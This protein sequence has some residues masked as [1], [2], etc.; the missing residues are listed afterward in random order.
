MILNAAEV[1]KCIGHPVR[2][3]ILELLDESREQTVTQ[4]H[5]RL[6]IDQP[7]A[8]QH[9]GLMRD[10]GILASRRKGVNVYYRIKDE[11]VIRVLDCLRDCDL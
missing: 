8:S 6:D 4:V 3:E 5:D 10:R 1:L 7:T 2:L 11:K 9:L